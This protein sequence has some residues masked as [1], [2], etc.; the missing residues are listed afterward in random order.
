MGMDTGDRNENR[1][2]VQVAASVTNGGTSEQTV[3]VTNLS[4]S[5]CRFTAYGTLRLGPLISIRAG[6]SALLKAR[7]KWRDGNTYGVRFE[8]PVPP[9]ILDHIRLFLSERP[10]LVADRQEATIAG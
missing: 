1:Y 6:R 7:V 5:G 2:D 8:D 9:A 3:K 10:A 4:S